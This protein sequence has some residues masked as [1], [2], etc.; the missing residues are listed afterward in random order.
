MPRR[1]FQPPLQCLATLLAILSLV[2]N[3]SAQFGSPPVAEIFSCPV[4]PPIARAAH[5]S[6]EVVVRFYIED[7]GSPS[8]IQVVSGP[9]MLRGSATDAIKRWRFH[10]PL[11]INAERDFEARFQF[12]FDDPDSADDPPDDLDAPPDIPAFSDVGYSYDSITS[13]VHSLDGTQS[14]HPPPSPPPPVCSSNPQPSTPPT[15]Q[16]PRDFIDL[17][18][19]HSGERD[20]SYRIRIFRDGTVEWEG[21]RNVAIT[22]HS[23]SRIAPATAQKLFDMLNAGT[24]WAQCPVKVDVPDDAREDD[25]IAV[26]IGGQ[27]GAVG[28]TVYMAAWFVHQAAAGYGPQHLA[29][30]IEKSADT[31]QWRHGDPSLESYANMLDDITLPKPGMTILIR[32]VLLGSYPCCDTLS[33][34]EKMLS[35]GIDLNEADSSG[36]TPLM[37]AMQIGYDGKIKR[38]LLKAHAAVNRRSARGDAAL[39]IAA[40]RGILDRDLLAAGADINLANNAGTTALMLL[41]ERGDPTVLKAALAAGADARIKD[42]DGHTALDYLQT[43]ACGKPL[44]PLEPIPPRYDDDGNLIPPPPLPPCPSTDPAVLE[45]EATLRAAM[46]TAL[47]R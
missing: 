8:S 29:W 34:F 42:R 37:Y 5:V 6:G 31:H 13:E 22:G 38:A 25:Y 1:K 20:A 4:Y 36:W 9:P 19:L 35:T 23:G 40:Y 30:A 3:A 39:L 27:D 7:D 26:Q 12:K 14:L 18:R 33:D 16:T 43:A 45:D 28:K 11:P 21:R 41:A 15:G 10:V 32:A 24:F 17:S 46:H 44:V 2:S 47:A